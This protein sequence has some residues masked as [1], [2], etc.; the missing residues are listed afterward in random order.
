MPTATSR[1]LRQAARGSLRW[2]TGPN[3]LPPQGRG[4]HPL[5]NLLGATGLLLLHSRLQG[6]TL[7]PLGPMWAMKSP[8]S[9]R[10]LLLPAMNHQQQLQS[11]LESLL[12]GNRVELT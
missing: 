2:Q 3:T 7:S 8:S 1:A 10:H 11:S 4:L 12:L 5:P 6:G 9:A